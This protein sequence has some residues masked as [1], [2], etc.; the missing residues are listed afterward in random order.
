MDISRRAIIVSVKRKNKA[1]IPY[2]D[3]ILKEW[4]HVFMYTQ[5]YGGSKGYRDIEKSAV[6]H[7]NCIAGFF[8]ESVFN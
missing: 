8:T 1:R 7:K 5:K 3:M 2:G 4:D 6:Q